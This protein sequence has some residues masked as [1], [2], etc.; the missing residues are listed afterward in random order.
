MHKRNLTFGISLVVAITVLACAAE[1]VDD[2]AANQD[3]ATM[4]P[5]FEVD[6]FWPKPLPNHWIQGATIGV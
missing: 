5:M 2:M 6:P 3:G 1:L 4:A